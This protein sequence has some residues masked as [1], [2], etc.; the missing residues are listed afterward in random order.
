MPGVWVHIVRAMTPNI[1][2][3]ELN[4]RPG[5]EGVPACRSSIGFVD[6]TNGILEYRGYG[7]VD[8]CKNSTFEEV[9]FL[10][11]NGK[12]PS[13]GELSE[14]DQTLRAHRKITE[15]SKNIIKALPKDGHPMSMLQ[16]IIAALGMQDQYSD[17]KNQSRNLNAIINIIA[18]MP[19]YITFFE[20]L[21]K[22][23]DPIE[24]DPSLN[25]SANF[26]YMLTGKKPTE[27][28]TKIFDVCLILHAEHTLNAS[29]FSARVTASTLTNPY[30]ALSAAVG[31]LYGPLHGGANESVLQ[32]LDQ[33]GS[34]KNVRTFVENKLSKK[35]KIM[36]VG[37]RVYKTKDPRAIAL[38][39][40]AAQLFAGTQEDELLEV[41][42]ELEKV[43][44]EKLA[45]KG[46]YPNVDFY[47]GLVYRKLGF[48]TDMFTPIFAAARSSGWA[49]HWIEQMADNKLFRPTQVYTGQHE[50]PY[51]PVA[52]R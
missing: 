46:I 43:V 33:I 38:Q 44:K 20:R 47:S 29:T 14:F 39:D 27:L 28:E 19:T 40:L 5:M 23:L 11:L 3:E 12:L 17:L 1:S 18:K 52:Q 37:H 42:K 24:P 34:V 31:T 10:L 49:A 25:H 32:M 26:I 50:V 2:Q 9:T 16:V 22:G 21:R 51:T 6:G 45:A 8:L 15:V 30:T 48:S 7:I 36:G 13:A 4:Y 41:A 35:E